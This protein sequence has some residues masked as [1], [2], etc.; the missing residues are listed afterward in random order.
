MRGCAS[1]R[2]HSHA[3]AGTDDYIICQAGQL[4]S[5]RPQV[6]SALPSPLSHWLGSTLPAEN[7]E[8]YS[9]CPS[10]HHHQ[11]SSAVNDI[12]QVHCCPSKGQQRSRGAEEHSDV[13]HNYDSNSN[14]CSAGEKHIDTS[15]RVFTRPV[16]LS[17]TIHKQLFEYTITIRTYGNPS[18]ASHQPST[19][20]T[21]VLPR[22]RTL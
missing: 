13:Q 9:V 17:I 2:V 5:T 6:F 16:L 19:C 3:S 12:T 21:H 8:H 11:I 4:R 22:T 7:H 15:F 1:H 10:I 20:L 14:G 18:S